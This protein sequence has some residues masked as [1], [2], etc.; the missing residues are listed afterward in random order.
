MA[1]RAWTRREW[2]GGTVAASAAWGMARAARAVDYEKPVPGSDQMTAYQADSE[3]IVRW[4]N[5]TLAAYRAHPSQKYPYFYPLAGPITGSPLTT[6]SSLPY[7]HH[8]GL[9]LGCEPLNGGDYWA[10]NALAKGQIRSL[11]LKLG[12][13]TPTSAVITD[14][15]RWERQG[16]P[17]PLEDRRTFTLLVPDERT[18]LLDVDLT[19][20]ALEPVSIFKAKHS[21]FALRC[22]P[23][24]APMYGGTLMNSEGGVGA[25]ATYGKPAA[26]CGY[27]GRRAGRPDVV[28]GIA[29]LDHPE[30][31]WSPC[32]WLTRDY[33]HLSPSPF[34]FIKQPW[35]LPAGASVRL[36][37]RVVLH[38]GDP[39][40]AGLDAIYKQWVNG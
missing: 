3:V 11:D 38:A 9:W 28:E 26:W 8:R 30:N 12:P 2:I 10:D 31:P 13:A 39:K 6:E 18:R 7:P 4:R 32:P 14:R 5:A 24:L 34:N 22:A 19:L 15:C 17:A 35:T 16:A 29:I 23:D 1:R 40:E 20:S 27:H 33:G 36:R 21:F 25:E 37:Y